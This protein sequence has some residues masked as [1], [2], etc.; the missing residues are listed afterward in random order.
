MINH[1]VLFKLNDYQAEEKRKVI[2]EMKSLLEGL[3]EKIKEVKFL[4][5]G[6]NYDLNARSYDI[7][8]ITHFDNLEALNEYRDHPEHIKVVEKIALWATSRAAVDF[9]F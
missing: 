2:T 3:K 1:V 4:Q 6:T 5:V 7:A 9:E 8:L